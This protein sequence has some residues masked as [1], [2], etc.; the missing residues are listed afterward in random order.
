MRRAA[1]LLMAAATWAPAGWS[2]AGKA[3]IVADL[4]RQIAAC[5]MPPR[6]VPGVAGPV[7]L[8]LQIGRDGALEA[9]PVVVD[10]PGGPAA[11][12]QFAASARRAVRA[13]APFDLPADRYETW[14][15]VKIT[16]HPPGT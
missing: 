3:E 9:E 6:P 12:E 16:F 13:C 14:K 8:S 15:S 1:T 7:T 10:N 2:Y 4:Q 11:S 5:W